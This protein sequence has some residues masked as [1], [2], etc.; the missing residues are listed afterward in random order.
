MNDIRFDDVKD[1]MLSGDEVVMISLPNG[2]V[3][4]KKQSDDYVEI[5]LTTFTKDSSV[6]TCR[7]AE[8]LNNIEDMQFDGV[9]IEKAQYVVVPEIGEHVLK[10]KFIGD[11]IGNNFF[12]GCTYFTGVKI[13]SNIKRIGETSFSGCTRL[14]NVEISEGVEVIEYGAFRD[15][16]ITDIYI[17]ASV[18]AINSPFYCSQLQH[19]AIDPENQTFG[20]F[21]SNSVIKKSNMALICGSNN[22]VVVNGV[23]R[24]GNGAL[25]NLPGLRSVTLPE[26]ITEIGYYAFQKSGVNEIIVD[27]KALPKTEYRTFQDIQ[28]GG[29]I[30]NN[31]AVDLSEWMVAD[32]YYLGY[33]EWTVS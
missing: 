1:V 28:V 30:R 18:N 33:Y 11:K 6:K 29:V 15:C 20:D 10:I 17:P 25:S 14:K 32:K 27:F 4:W 31:T 22:T 3:L 16:I 7:L 21:G 24:I 9:S 23:N 5:T 12:Y 13:P 2:I 8:Y 26:T 19:I